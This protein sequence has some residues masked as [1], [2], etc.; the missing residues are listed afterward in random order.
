VTAASAAPAGSLDR[1]PRRQY[2]RWAAIL[3]VVELASAIL[4]LARGFPYFGSGLIPNAAWWEVP[5]ALLH[6]PAIEALSAAGLC[7][8]LRNGLVLTHV[9]RG[10]H[11]RM[12]LT[13][14]GILAGSNWL[15]WLAIVLLG[16]WLWNRRRKQSLPPPEAASA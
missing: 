9:I 2:R 8:G 7:C 14:T 5:L 16:Q 13:G 3:L 1:H 11:I 10:G 4:F 15:C 12:T 6:L